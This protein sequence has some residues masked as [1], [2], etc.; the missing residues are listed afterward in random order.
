MKPAADAAKAQLVDRREIA[1]SP[2]AISRA[3]FSQ[4]SYRRP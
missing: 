3:P 4:G 1:I 2:E